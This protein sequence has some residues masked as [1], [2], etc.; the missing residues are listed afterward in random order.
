MMVLA[1][2][3]VAMRCQGEAC[4]YWD[5]L[6]LA[7]VIYNA[8]SVPLEAGFTYHKSAVQSRMEDVID[9]L[10]ALDVF[11]TFRTSYVD[12][13]AIVVRDGAKI[14]KHYLQTWF[15][16]DILASLPLEY[17]ILLFGFSGNDNLTY[18]AMLKVR[19]SILSWLL[20]YSDSRPE[21]SRRHQATVTHTTAETCPLVGAGCIPV[22]HQSAYRF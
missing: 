14:A 15:P 17:I 7:F 12:D 16:I 11:Y 22:P 4:R 9:V 18:F 10:F 21:G 8:V 1:E 20:V 19:S 13:Q 6:I 5:F 3:L 2:L